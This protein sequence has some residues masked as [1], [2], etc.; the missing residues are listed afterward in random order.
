MRSNSKID[1]DTIFKIYE[2]EKFNA[3]DKKRIRQNIRRYF[4]IYLKK[5][6]IPQKGWHDLNEADREYFICCTIRD[7]LKKE[8][9]TENRILQRIDKRLDKR[10]YN[11]LS[12]A[13]KISEE[14]NAVLDKIRVECWEEGCSDAKKKEKYKELCEILQTYDKRIPL[15]RFEE[16]CKAQLE[17][18][19]LRKEQADEEQLR[20]ERLELEQA[21][22]SVLAFHQLRME[23]LDKEQADKE[24]LAIEQS[25]IEQLTGQQ[26]DEEQLDEEQPK[27]RFLRPYDYIQSYYT[28]GKD[29]TE[30]LLRIVLQVLEEKFDLE[31]NYG[32][33]E[34][35][36]TT[37]KE[38]GIPHSEDYGVDKFSALPIEYTDTESVNREDFE[39]YLL[40]Q[41]RFLKAREMLLDLKPFYKI[42]RFKN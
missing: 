28:F 17:I 21:R 9:E 42:N 20:K 38:T 41:G 2:L 12:N 33:I 7:L 36:L 19:K 35:C 22:E 24:Q 6:G 26:S 13:Y 30:V 14:R 15:P 39:K 1:Y 18:E 25:A 3:Y 4:E 8:H 27:K 10:L 23:E 29:N 11:T 40:E 34:E 32:L 37:V 16:F 31:I 5:K